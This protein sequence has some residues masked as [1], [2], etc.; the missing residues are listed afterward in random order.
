MLGS[1]PPRPENEGSDAYLDAIEGALLDHAREVAIGCVDPVHGIVRHCAFV[2]TV[3]EIHAWC[4]RASADMRDVLRR[5]DERMTAA[6]QAAKLRAETEAT[7]ELTLEERRAVVER[8]RE[9]LGRNFGMKG[10]DAVDVVRAKA[11]GMSV[12]ELAEARAEADR[13]LRAAR[14][15]S[16]KAFNERAMLAQYAARGIDPVRDEAGNVVSIDLVA[17]VNP[18]LLLRERRRD[19]EG[20]VE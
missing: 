7:N 3:A 13:Q 20:A 19:A 9:R 4:D 8:F 1:Y 6:R 11:R 14:S 2:P 15:A 18:A 16:E 10:I 17:S 5:D 12:E